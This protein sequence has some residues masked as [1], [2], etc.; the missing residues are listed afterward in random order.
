MSKTDRTNWKTSV[1]HGKP[2]DEPDDYWMEMKPGERM[3]FAWELSLTAWK[4][5]NPDYVDEP[6]LS[7]SV[8]RVI[9]G[10]R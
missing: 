7:R 8:A 5:A 9:R 3:S 2:K 1:S 4:I 10:K 6:G